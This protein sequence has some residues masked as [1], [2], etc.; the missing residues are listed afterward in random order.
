MAYRMTTSKAAMLRCRRRQPRLSS[1]RAVA[2]IARPV[3]LDL[4]VAQCIVSNHI[5]NPKRNST[6]T[7]RVN[8]RWYHNRE[9][10]SLQWKHRYNV[11]KRKRG[12]F[13]HTP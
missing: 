8:L 2:P 12:H 5:H 3:P 13:K 10:R 4:L 1:V 7:I 11:P 9:R 6:K